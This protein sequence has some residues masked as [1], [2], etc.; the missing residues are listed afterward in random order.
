MIRYTI[1]CLVAVIPLVFADCA[2]AQTY[3]MGPLT[4]G[5][6]TPANYYNS[7]VIVFGTGFSVNGTTGNFEFSINPE[8]SAFT[9]AFSQNRNYVLTIAPRTSGLTNIGALNSLEPCQAEETIQYY[10]GLGR[11]LQTVQVR[12]SPLAN[13]IVK[14]FAYDAFEREPVKYMPYTITSG[15]SDG[16]YRSGALTVNAGQDAFYNAP[17][18]GVTAIN[19]A[20]APT[21]FESSPLNRMVEQGAPGDP[22]QLGGTTGLAATPGHTTKLIYCSN[23]AANLTAGSG[24]WVR[25]YTVNI[26]PST[27]VRTLVDNGGTG[28]GVN[29]LSA[30]ITQDEN[31]T[32]TQ[33]D[34][35]LNT[36]ET[37]KDK[38]GHLLLKR[39]YNYTTSLQV[40]STYFVYDDFGNLCYVLPPQA[41]PDGGMSGTG[42]QATLN[43]LCYQYTYDSKQRPVTKQIPGKG[44]VSTVYNLID[45]P[46]CAQDANQQNRQE[47]AYVKY[48]VLG[49]VVI[50]GISLSNT[51]SRTSMQAAIT[52]GLLNSTYTEWEKSGTAAQGYSNTAYPNSGTMVALTANYYDGYSFTG[53]P[54]TFAAPSGASAMTKGLLTASKT[55][56]LN[57][58]YNA[59][60]DMLWMVSYYDDL[61]RITQ[62]YSE[63]YLGGTLSIYNYDQFNNSYDF[64]NV[65]TATTRQHYVLNGTGT[66][67]VINLTVANGYTYDHMGR[68]IQTTETVNSGTRI[69]LSQGSYNELGQLMMKSLHSTDD[70]SFYQ[71]IFYSYNERGWLT[72]SS[73]NLFAEQLQYNAN[74]LN[75]AGFT[76]QYNGNIA[77]QTR[78][79]GQATPTTTAYTY[80]YDYLDRLTKAIS[81]DN[82]NES[83][84]TYDLNGNIT[85][86]QRTAG[87]TTNIDNLSYTYTNASGIYT[88]QVQNITDNATDA[89]GSGYPH[90]TFVYGYDSNGNINSDASKLLNITTYNQ[91]NLSQS[92]T[93]NGVTVT[94]VYDAAGRKLRKLSTAGAGSTT[95]YIDGLEYDNGTLS[96]AQT[97]EG[98]VLLTGGIANYEYNLTDHLGNN[99]LS[100]DTHAAVPTPTQQ[101]DYYAF[102]YEIPRG[103]ATNPKN[104]YLYNKKEL[105]EDLQVYDYGARSYDPVIAR[106]S[107]V[108]NLSENYYSFSPYI[109]GAE[110]PVRNVDIDGNKFT[111]GA[112]S[113]VNSMCREMDD[114]EKS[115]N[116]TIESDKEKLAK[117]GLSEKQERKLNNE[118]SRLENNNCEFKQQRAE[119]AVLAVSDQVYGINVSS[120]LNG[121]GK[122]VAETSFNF[123]SKEVEITIGANTGVDLFA[124]EM[125]HCFQFETG[126][127]SLAAFGD[128]K[129]YAFL[130]DQLDEI[131]A[132]DRQN[133]FQDSKFGNGNKPLL[134]NRY[135]GLPTGPVNYANYNLLPGFQDAIKNKDNVALNQ[136]AQFMR[137]AFRVNNVTYYGY[138]K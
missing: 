138:P 70:V 125:K 10:D 137:Q 87:T 72:A 114:D 97:E 119:L 17:P 102:G 100:F 12:A 36:T 99:R 62:S 93:A 96:F 110:N 47:W 111:D 45:K 89:S 127:I 35:R 118:I 25:M 3:I 23:D 13:D 51:S 46:V 55:T 134:P 58:M 132:Y 112:M 106:W 19:T 59:T 91:L 14:P 15:T 116:K 32:S 82:Y 78:T 68:K 16:S 98:R 117:G 130:H 75:L 128:D 135:L 94:Y 53:K 123:D 50:T 49:R 27:G 85:A 73:A 57:T 48:D 42:N 122:E 126:Q 124:H 9:N 26:D 28:Y 129:T 30:I 8:C 60:P 95:D 104:E 43:A 76:A 66:G 113:W 133:A 121:G 136:T 56:I 65:T 6:L 54:S 52:A 109:Y 64:T 71:N 101:D 29:Q 107:G 61:G 80:T 92:L 38:E 69:I 81:T 33:T 18:M 90:G 5:T 115:N 84:I 74:K 103:A 108:D 79:A 21:A 41:N 20:S 40:L 67:S 2:R 1:I 86:L 31:W 44:V 22:W 34:A 7:N 11:P 24:R 4:T 83:G 120:E 131:E 37:Y 39:T 77:S 88:N 105:Q 63:H